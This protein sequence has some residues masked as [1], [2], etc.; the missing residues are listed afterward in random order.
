ML[1]GHIIIS[2]NKNNRMMSYFIFGGS[3]FIGTH[4][5]TLIDNLYPGTKVYNLDIVEN[6][7]EGKSTYINCD[8]RSDINI[9]V[10]V[11]SED[12]IFNF[13]AVHRTPGHP[14]QQDEYEHQ[15]NPSDRARHSR[16][17]ERK[18]VV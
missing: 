3:G 7:H 5:I 18:S 14:D 2:Y 9:D 16:I 13:A 8:V 4:L 15:P 17:Q 10:L 1:L 6:N 12:V 11:T